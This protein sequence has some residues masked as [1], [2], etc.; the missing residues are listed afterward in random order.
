MHRS[1]EELIVLSL[2]L[3]QL[4]HAIHP[5]PATV[6]VTEQC[7]LTDPRYALATRGNYDFWLSL[8]TAQ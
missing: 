1:P 5:Q 7:D 6:T 2:A 3:A 8:D 4:T